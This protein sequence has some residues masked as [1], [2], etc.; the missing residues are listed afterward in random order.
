MI[1]RMPLLVETGILEKPIEELDLSAR[2][3]NICRQ[4]RVVTIGDLVKALESNGDIAKWRN[5]GYVTRKEIHSKLFNYQFE[6][7]PDQDIWCK[8]VIELNMGSFN[9]KKISIPF[10]EVSA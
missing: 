1:L 6:N 10:L 7:A 4:N 2:S 3:Y 9:P 5:C 8:R